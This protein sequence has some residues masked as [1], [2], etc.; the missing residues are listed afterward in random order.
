MMRNLTVTTAATE[1]ALTTLVQLKADLGLDDT[2]DTFYQRVIDIASDE[3]AV[4][5]GRE[6]DDEGGVTLGRETIKETFYGLRCPLHLTL[7]RYPLAYVV[8]VVENG[9][10][11]TR[12]ITGSD[13]AITSGD[14][15]FSSAGASFTDAYV[16][17]SI[18]IPGAGAAAA[19][20]TTTIASVTDGTTVELATNAG[21]TVSGASY[22]I[23][24]PA[25]NYIVKKSTGTISK[26]V[27]GALAT[28]TGEI[29]TINYL[30][31]WLLPEEAGRNLPYGIEDACILLCQH[32][33][34]LMQSA[35]NF[36]DTL[37]S[38][39]IE[40]VGDVEFG[41]TAAERANSL[42]FDVRSLLARYLQPTMA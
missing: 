39:K 20:L 22:E 35:A 21:T 19:S 33:I 42:P 12:L 31:G 3:I 16:G 14:A 38:V 1:K 28:F 4:Y 36:S 37:K 5:L 18:T 13:G 40:G 23:A 2:Q 24:N 41:N 8:S 34:P 6:A 26:I 29:V 10:T 25:F 15:T 32:K 27:G 11:V 30:S 17:Q 7:A 9:A